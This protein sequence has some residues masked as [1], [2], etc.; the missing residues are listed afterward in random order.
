MKKRILFLDHTAK[1]SGG[2]RS[3]LLILE[4]LN[5]RRFTPFLVTLED[6]PLLKS[7][8]LLG[9]ESISIPIPRMIS[10]RER[11]RTGFLFLLISLFALLPTVIAIARFTRKNRIDII[12]TNSQKAHLIGI[13]AGIAAGIPVFWHFR[14]ILS[15]GILLRL[16]RY[17]GV[18]FAEHIIAIS[19]AVASQFRICGRQHE[20]VKVV[21]NALDIQDFEKQSRDISVDLRKEFGLPQDAKIA[22]S[23]GQIAEWKGQEYLLRAAKELVPDHSDL[24]FFI[25]GKPLFREQGYYTLLQ[26]LVRELG[27]DGKVLF[28]GFR[29]DIPAVMR[30]ID[31]LVHTPVSP[32]PFGRVLIEAMVCNTP[33]IAFDVGA[34]REIVGGHTG[35]RIPPYD[36]S[37][38][39]R[40]I[41]MLLEDDKRRSEIVRR[42]RSSAKIRFDYPTL[43]RKIELLLGSG[44]QEKA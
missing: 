41:T 22:A 28:T 3:L 18:L 24:Y 42:A 29:S 15:E 34:V 10:E 44:G 8:Q 14:D 23:V 35:I 27:L 32:E 26:K 36:V 39:V 17:S 21:Y 16:M 20:K 19:E 9:A 6:G 37:G 12:Y 25:V 38:L 33:V 43:I 40:S 13:G 5:R 7:A 4:K 1:L 11:S 30:N 31:I 2:E